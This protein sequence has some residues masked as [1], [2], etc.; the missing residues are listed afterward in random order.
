ML[1]GER[2]TMFVTE[3]KRR[4]PSKILPLE[5]R[6]VDMKN[7]EVRLDAGTTKNDEGRVFPFTTNLRNSFQARI[8]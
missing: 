4:R 3:C 8:V 5:W 7:G 6:Q 1:S 2:Q